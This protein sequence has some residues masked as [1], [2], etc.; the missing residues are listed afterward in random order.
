MLR[1]ETSDQGFRLLEHVYSIFDEGDLAEQTRICQVWLS[2][3]KVWMVWD[4]AP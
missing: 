3:L 4:S 2:I 1:E